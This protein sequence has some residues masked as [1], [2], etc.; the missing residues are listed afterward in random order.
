MRQ[1]EK[2]YEGNIRKKYFF[3][4]LPLV[5][6]SLLSQSY[7]FINSMM[8]GKFIGSEAFAATAVTAQLIEFI[9]SIFFGYLTGV[10]IYVSVLFGK[11]EQKKMLNVIK[12][13][14][15]LSSIFAVFIT[16]FCNLFCGWIFKVLNVSA[17]IYRD[18]ELYFRTYVSGLLFFQ[19]NWG[20]TYIA[21]GM[22][23]TRMPLA[24]SVITGIFNISLNYL[25]LAVFDK[26][27]GYSALA[28]MI[29]ASA[30][31]VVYIVIFANLF[32]NMGLR[33]GGF[34][35]NKNELKGS[36]DYGTPSMLQQMAMYGCSAMV[37]PLVNTCSTAAL[38]GYAIANKAQALICA[39]YQSSSKA[40]TNFV[41]Q[42]M[43]AKKIDKIKQGIKIGIVQGLAFFGLTLGLFVIFAPQF[44]RLFLDPVADAESFQVSI[45]I[46][47]YLL[48][49]LLV[50]VF[51]NLFHG[52]FRAIG[53]GTLML[54]S[55]LIYAVSFVIYANI[56]FALLPS[57][58]KIYG[59][60][61]ALGASYVTE[62]IFATI[63]FITGKWKTPEYRALESKHYTA[64]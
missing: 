19:L 22:G 15:L 58:M 37:S 36:I 50:N 8:I 43:G 25:F 41:A 53:S 20:F 57:E 28:T 13:N 29:A 56:L 62:V 12:V 23:F 64:Q 27:I 16:L 31:A 5:L 59:A 26:G 63:I 17:D 4:A 39:V 30:V 33:L 55:T 42:A 10:G 38:S 21:N 2:L 47:R 45:Y 18:A 11:G 54:I 9:N 49:L 3:F 14:L 46:I 61:L 24:A 60:H 32:K 6:S 1:P 51:N 40:N 48:P 7:T 35:L 52:I 44:T 34:S